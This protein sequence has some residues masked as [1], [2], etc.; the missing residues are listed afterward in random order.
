MTAICPPYFRAFLVQLRNSYDILT[1]GEPDQIHVV[2]ET[3]LVIRQTTTAPRAT[4]LAGPPR[5]QKGA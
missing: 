3:E 4:E 5:A 1:N 2:I